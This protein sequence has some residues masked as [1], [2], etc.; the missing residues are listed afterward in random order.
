MIYIGTHLQLPYMKEAPRERFQ[1]T[2]KKGYCYFNFP[3]PAISAVNSSMRSI[4]N[5]GRHIGFM[6][7]DINFIGLSSAATRF[8][9]NCP[10]RRQRWMIAH[11]PFLRT[12]TDTG[13]MILPQSDSRSPG[14]LSKC[15]L[16][17]QFGQ[18]FLWL[19]PAPAETTNR[20]QFLQ[21]KLSAQGWFL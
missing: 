4:G 17:K 19:L 12:H 20:P 10:Q 8:E 18:W 11:S 15:I 16:H 2:L 5:G 1:A 7:I 13:S 6:A 14:S 3:S 21:T 9:Q